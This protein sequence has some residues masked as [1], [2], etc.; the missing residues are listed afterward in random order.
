MATAQPPAAPA[1]VSVWEDFIDIFTSPS[2]VFSRRANGQVW[3]ALVVIVVLVATFVFA[4]TGL[5]AP[6]REA[7]FNRMVPEV[8]KKYPQLTMDQLQQR[9]ATGEKIGWIIVA[10]MV[11]ITMLVMGL[12]T[13]IVG[14]FFSAKT[15]FADAMTITT[16][17]WIPRLVGLIASG[18]MAALMDASSMTSR[19]SASLSV[20]RFLN[21]DT[22]A[23]TLFMLAGRVDVFI[24]WQTV[25][26]AIGLSSLGKIP[27]SQAYLA[28]A[29]LF[30]LGSLL[31][32]LS[33]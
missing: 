22:T 31:S 30:V 17:A 5:F 27:R 28:A 10:I 21:P 25:L 26:Y 15:T 33:P 29:I 1:K 3:V 20:A 14:K 13:W 24:A 2:E 16:Y 9:Q 32:L 23:H 6:M 11:P 19:F 4:T 8:L 7:E 18:I 12:L